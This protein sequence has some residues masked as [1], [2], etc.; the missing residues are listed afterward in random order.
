MLSGKKIL[1]GITGSIAAYK[2]PFLV[3]L[4]LKEGAEV[5][6]L[7]T[8][9]AR[10]FVTPLTLATLSKRTVLSEPFH[11]ADGKWN[12]H[13]D[14]GNWADLFLM[15]PLT[16]NTMA[17]MAHGQADNL[18]V[19]TYMAAR[20]PVLFAPAMD[21]DMFLHPTTQNNIRILQSFGNVLIAPACGELASGLYGEGRMEEPAH[22]LEIILKEL[23]KKES[24][25]GLKVLVTAGP[26]YEAV[27]PVRFIGNHSSGLMGYAVAE[28]MASMGA[29]VT[30]VSGPTHLEAGR[31]GITKICVTSA[32][33]MYE[34]C[35]KAFPEADVT[36]MAAAVADF[37]PEDPKVN[38]ISK[39]DGLKE[40]R[41]KPTR[42]I[43]AA[44]GKTKTQRQVL[45]G[46]ALET[47]NALDHACAKL[48]SKNLDLIVVN[49]LEDPG[50]GFGHATNKVSLISRDGNVTGLPLK[51]KKE[52][53]TDIACAIYSFIHR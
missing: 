52:V 26:T 14:L 9:A 20:C 42:D 34:A 43:L 6:V 33:E 11:L 31:P 19:C 2:I 30:L 39:K 53:A 29:S 12:S 37:A 3:R 1:I 22:I 50:A 4:L 7:M 24:F 25:E 21:V 13:I 8:P 36:V 10:D 46:F 28:E 48:Q 38:K 5:Q 18:L 47:E 35:M 27:D 45:V 23:K 17:K 44:M 16:A 40:I 41:L 51:P 32:Q 49:S 15:A